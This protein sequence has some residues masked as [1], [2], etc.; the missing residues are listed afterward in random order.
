MLAYMS[1]EI[2]SVSVTNG[3]CSMLKY[4]TNKKDL[5]SKI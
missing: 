2:A 4:H 1:M 3:S 5:L